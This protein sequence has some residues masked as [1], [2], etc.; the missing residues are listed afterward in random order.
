MTGKLGVGDVAVLTQGEKDT[1]ILDTS[2]LASAPYLATATPLKDIQRHLDWEVP[3]RRHAPAGT[4]PVILNVW[5]TADGKVA[6]VTIG[7]DPG[8]GTAEEAVRAVKQC[9]RWKPQN[10]QYKSTA[11]KTLQSFYFMVSR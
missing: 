7:R 6:D 8:Y 1:Y 2:S 4:Y 5:I 11:R 10:I 3:V 9:S